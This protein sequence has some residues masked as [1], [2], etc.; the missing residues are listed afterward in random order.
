MARFPQLD[1]LADY[2]EWLDWKRG[3]LGRA[4]GRN[5]HTKGFKGSL[6]PLDHRYPRDDDGDMMPIIEDDEE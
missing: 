4:R 5:S 6:I 2:S 1:R 3:Q